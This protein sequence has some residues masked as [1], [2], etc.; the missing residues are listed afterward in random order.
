LRCCDDALEGFW[1]VR[2]RNV[3]FRDSLLSGLCPAFP[4]LWIM[5]WG[6]AVSRQMSVSA[7]LVPFGVPCLPSTYR[8]AGPAT[9]MSSVYR[10]HQKN[11]LYG[12]TGLIAG[13]SFY[14][15]GRNV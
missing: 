4:S 10:K 1:L 13:N 9:D 6:C 14:N 3:R 2:H 7:G 11:L 5:R 8:R 12:R 15:P